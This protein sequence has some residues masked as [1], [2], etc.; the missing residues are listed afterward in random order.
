MTDWN[1]QNELVVR[2]GGIGYGADT[3][4][5]LYC[6]L[7]EAHVAAGTP[8]ETTLTQ[9]GWDFSG[10]TPGGVRVVETYM[11]RWSLVKKV[12]K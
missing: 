1:C 11:V 7:K 2:E 10:P 6:S 3:D 5:Q 8:H 9:N 12:P 4:A